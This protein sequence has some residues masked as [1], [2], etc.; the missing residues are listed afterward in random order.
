MSLQPD[1]D[2]EAAWSM[3]RRGK[4]EDSSVHPNMGM[5]CNEDPDEANKTGNPKGFIP[6]EANF[7]KIRTSDNR[8]V[9]LETLRNLAAIQDSHPPCGIPAKALPSFE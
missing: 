2:A 7:G 8:R 1:Q 3:T 6:K 4:T 9:S 5:G